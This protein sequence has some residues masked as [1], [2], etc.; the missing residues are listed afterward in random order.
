MLGFYSIA[1]DAISGMI[2]SGSSDGD[3]GGFATI[4]AYWKRKQ[5]LEA[6][7]ADLERR[8]IKKH[9]MARRRREEEEA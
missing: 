9:E 3:F 4:G 1:S 6:K 2:A 7:R 8:R 5:D